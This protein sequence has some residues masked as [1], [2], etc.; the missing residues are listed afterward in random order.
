MKVFLLYIFFVKNNDSNPLNKL[1]TNNKSRL[2]G[3]RSFITRLWLQRK[4]I[5][6]KFFPATLNQTNKV[7]TI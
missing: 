3:T 6:R 1:R 4:A 2:L 5:L 7:G